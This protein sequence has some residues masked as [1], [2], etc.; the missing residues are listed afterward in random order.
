[1]AKITI[2]LLAK[3]NAS[4]P[5][6]DVSKSIGGLA[7]PTENA[8][9][10]FAG[11]A[12]GFA[13]TALSGAAVGAAFV[14]LAN[15]LNEAGKTAGRFAEI[16]AKQ[17]AILRAT[18]NAAGYT[19]EQLD[20]MARE[21]TRTTEL[22]PS[23]VKEAQSLMLTFRNIG[24]QEFPRAMQAAADLQTTFGGLQSSV[25]QLGK[26]LNDPIRGVTALGEAGV[27]FSDQ[28]KEMIRNFVEMGDLA[29]AQA[30]ILAE[31]EAQVG[32]TAEAIAAA[33]DGSGRL[34]ASLE[35]LNAE[36]GRGVLP[37][38]QRWNNALADTVDAL[39]R[40]TRQNREY[41]ESAMDLA[42]ESDQVA[43]ALY[44]AERQGGAYAGQ[45]ER[46]ILFQQRGA[47]MTR[48]YS[49]QLMATAQ[50]E[51]VLAEAT[52]DTAAA[53][54]KSNMEFLRLAGTLSDE[55]AKAN[56]KANELA[57]ERQRI[58]GEMA[59]A[60]AQGYS[61]TGEKVQGYMSKLDELAAKEA[62]AADAAEIAGRRR[63]LSMLEQQLAIDGLDT[64]EME[65][66][67]KLGQ[68]WGIYS[69]T[70]VNEA[71]AVISEVDRLKGALANLPEGKDIN[72]V[73]SILM[74][75]VGTGNG[76]Q[77]VATTPA[78]VGIEMRAAGGP[79]SAGSP[80]IVGE[81]GAELFVP[82]SS[83]MIVP[84]SAMGGGGN[85]INIVVNGAQDAEAVADEIARMLQ[86][87]GVLA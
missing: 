15:Y 43:R 23:A 38:Q 32:G 59:T 42:E 1:M 4:K 60:I 85:T 26:A 19:G 68:Q 66:L 14:A 63:V 31:V 33:G 39:E 35:L 29:S 76:G 57:K 79:V 75:F 22:M 34:R 5:V 72:V 50:A 84:N 51:T 80:Y 9:T 73:M 54:S 12:K 16:N 17:E 7:K 52:E 44:I 86:R 47:E 87:Q 20:A 3:D 46:M 74:N 18:G 70:A 45:I 77:V 81:Q 64:R 56:E 83:G 58:E 10:Q 13:A 69:E 67:L 36:I 25:M 53:V 6:K 65:Y 11:L 21:L 41:T 27:T 49:Q 71:Q 62:E 8:M 61:Q 24:G 78:G 28:Q 37:T 48:F 82:N 55:G 2:E 40:A 30:V